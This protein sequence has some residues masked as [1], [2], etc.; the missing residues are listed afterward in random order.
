MKLTSK[1]AIAIVLILVGFAAGFPIGRS[2][3]FTTGSEWALVQAN[4]VARETGVFMPVYLYD[5]DF[6]VV[7]KQPRNLYKKARHLAEKQEE[8][9][10]G[11]YKVSALRE[12]R[13]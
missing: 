2:T 9:K 3:G 5:E 8:K 10:A 7:I 13:Q 11:H 6:R 4:I 1:M 12:R